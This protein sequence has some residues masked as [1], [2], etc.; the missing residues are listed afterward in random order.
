MKVTVILFSFVEMEPN[1]K[2]QLK[3]CCLYLCTFVSNVCTMKRYLVLSYL[4]LIKE[5]WGT[6]NTTI[7]NRYT[8]IVF[9]KLNIFR[10]KK[11]L[12]IESSFPYRS[13]FLKSRIQNNCLNVF[14]KVQIFVLIKKMK[15]SSFHH[16]KIHAKSFSNR[17]KQLFSHKK[18]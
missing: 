5:S 13:P 15:A 8:K 11:R 18:Q 1:W 4:F 16:F 9:L 3:F 10:C 17:S 12:N 6:Q 7:C 14:L 2:Y